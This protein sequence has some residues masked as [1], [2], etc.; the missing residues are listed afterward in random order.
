MYRLDVTKFCFS[1]SR[2]AFLRSTSGK[3]ARFERELPGAEVRV[4]GQ[5]MKPAQA[6]V[7][8]QLPE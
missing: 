8:Q 2:K 4:P 6:C 1:S 5:G 7:Q 3:P